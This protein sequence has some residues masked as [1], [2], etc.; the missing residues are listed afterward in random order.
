MKNR[1]PYVVP[2]SPFVLKLL[3]AQRAIQPS[4]AGHVLEGGR[5]VGSASV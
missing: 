2:L 5:S 1:Q 3:K 4:G